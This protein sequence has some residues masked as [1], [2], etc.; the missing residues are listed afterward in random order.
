MKLLTVCLD[1]QLDS[2][3]RLILQCSQPESKTFSYTWHSLLFSKHPGSFYGAATTISHD[4]RSISLDPSTAIDFLQT[5]DKPSTLNIQKTD[6][7]DRLEHDAKVIQALLQGENLESAKVTPSHWAWYDAVIRLQN[8]RNTFSPVQNEQ[9]S[10]QMMPFQLG[11]RLYEPDA[12]LSWRL[13]VVACDK[14]TQNMITPLNA[15]IEDVPASWQSWWHATYLKLALRELPDHLHLPRSFETLELDEKE[16]VEFLTFTSPQLLSADIP[17]FFPSDWRGARPPQFGIQ[18]SPYVQEDTVKADSYFHFDWTLSVE[19]GAMDEEAFRQLLEEGHRLFKWGDEWL[20]M[21]PT[22]LQA[23]QRRLTFLQ[24]KGL[25]LADLVA[26][27]VYTSDQTDGEEELDIMLDPSTPE[28]YRSLIHQLRHRSSPEVTIPDEFQGKLRPYQ[29]EGVDWLV[30]LKSWGLGGCL[31]DDMGLGKT[32]QISA[33]LAYIAKQSTTKAPFLLVVP[34]SLLSHWVS[35]LDKFV[36]FLSIYTHHGQH[37][38]KD[39]HA[40]TEILSHQVIITTYGV[41]VQDYHWL[42]DIQWEIVCV[43]EAQHIKNAQ[44]RQSRA[45]KALQS[46][47]KVALTGTPVENRLREM[48]ALMDLV[49]PGYLGSRVQFHERFVLPYEKND[50]LERLQTL[51]ALISP[52]L[53]R[54][55]KAELPELSLPGK[56]ENTVMCKLSPIQATLYQQWADYALQTVRQESGIRRRGVILAMITKLKQICDHPGLVQPSYKRLDEGLSLKMDEAR[57][58]L[59]D[60][61]AAGQSTI[62]FTQFKSM[63]ELLQQML[64]EHWQ[65][66]VP[67]LS[68]S[69]PAHQ[70]AKMIQSFQKGECPA[71]ILSLRAGGTGL[72][73]TRASHVIHYDRWW[74]PAV[75][76]QATDRAHRIGQTNDVHVHRLLVQGT[77]E[78]RIN[79][80]IERKKRLQDELLSSDQWLSELSDEDFE[81]LLY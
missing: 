78:E 46:Q 34:T 57:K 40:T 23:I 30:Q 17:V 60:I 58:L 2:Q 16:A 48:W 77:L 56:H 50:D 24:S 68:G 45:V 59:A 61:Y 22:D 42:K 74:N 29:K 15:S 80:V 71:M 49:N 3:H 21:D 44:T 5:R 14:K 65:K 28:K 8:K 9:T 38:L 32:V 20:L 35:E 51:K 62:I 33:F 54:R 79:E 70:R 63:G 43:D 10:N 39:E 53:L 18:V 12:K 4:G 11:V 67:F 36:P 52:F 25:S 19:E 76:S 81:Q 26:G 72:N 41:V 69:V 66:H 55:T 31:A 37:R 7:Y 6:A 64:L 27:K 75:E 1:A 47:Q 73:L 13:E